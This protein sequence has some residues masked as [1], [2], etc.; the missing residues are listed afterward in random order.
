MNAQELMSP[1]PCDALH[2]SSRLSI[3]DTFVDLYKQHV[4]VNARTNCPVT[5]EAESDVLCFLQQTLFGLAF[6][7][8][9]SGLQTWIDSGWWDHLL[10]LL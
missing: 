9:C 7:S 10:G 2:M 5:S 6:L 3:Y 4:L 1:L 8:S